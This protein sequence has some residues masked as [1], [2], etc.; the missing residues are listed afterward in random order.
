MIANCI[1]Y[2]IDGLKF[3]KAIGIVLAMMHIYIS[4]F[5]LVDIIIKEE[6]DKEIWMES[7]LSV[8]SS[9]YE[10]MYV[11]NRFVTWENF[12]YSKNIWL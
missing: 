3:W 8:C 12:F 11:K 9:K 7:I 4:Y 6:I 10:S 5:Y 1:E 2:L